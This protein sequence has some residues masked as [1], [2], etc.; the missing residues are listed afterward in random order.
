MSLARLGRECRNAPDQQASG[1]VLCQMCVFKFEGP[2]VAVF[3][4]EIQTANRQAINPPFKRPEQG[5]H[6][7]AA[8]GPRAA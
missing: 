5:F 7:G 8:R 4:S 6:G 3:S 2:L 1:S